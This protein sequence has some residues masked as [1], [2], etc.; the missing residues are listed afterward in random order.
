M[1]YAGWLFLP[2][3]SQVTISEQAGGVGAQTR[4]LWGHT[5]CGSGS[6][7]WCGSIPDGSTLVVEWATLP[8]NLYLRGKNSSC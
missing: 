2:A 1:Q 3:G 6:R 5:A 4:G 7:Y 8:G